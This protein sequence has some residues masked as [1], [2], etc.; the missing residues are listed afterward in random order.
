ML[1]RRVNKI[2]PLMTDLETS[3]AFGL[4]K[5]WL[6]Q[7]KK[8]CL[9]STKS[10]PFLLLVVPLNIEYR[11]KDLDNILNWIRSGK[12]TELDTPTGMYSKIDQMLPLKQNQAPEDRVKDIEVAFD[13]SRNRNIPPMQDDS[14]DSSNVGSVP[15]SR[16]TR[17]QRADVLA[18]VLNWPRNKG[19][20]DAIN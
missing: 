9:S 14:P 7:P 4:A 20:A 16:Q 13:L 10:R 6:Q 19:V 15:M 8:H 11:I 12:T 17:E 5:G 18:N 2:S 1:S 3:K